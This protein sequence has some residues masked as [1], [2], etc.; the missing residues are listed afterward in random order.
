M[1]HLLSL[2]HFSFRI[3]SKQLG[4]INHWLRRRIDK[5]YPLIFSSIWTSWSLFHQSVHNHGK[6][7]FVNASFW[8]KRVAIHKLLRPFNFDLK[9]YPPRKILREVSRVS[10]LILRAKP[11]LANKVLSHGNRFVARVRRRYFSEREK[12]RPEIRLLFA[13]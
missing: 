5:N 7:T 8:G 9:T 11:W 3:W 1:M 10:S 4:V 13:G 2:G 6:L 12:R